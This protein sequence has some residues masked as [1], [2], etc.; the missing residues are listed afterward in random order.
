MYFAIGCRRGAH[1]HE[2]CRLM[3]GEHGG[4]L[5]DRKSGHVHRRHGVFACRHFPCGRVRMAGGNGA[6]GSARSI[7]SVLAV[8]TSHPRYTAHC[9]R[10]SLCVPLHAEELINVFLSFSPGQRNAEAYFPSTRTRHRH[11]FFPSRVRAGD[12]DVR[13][14][15]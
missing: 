12:D 8:N 15:N 9:G 6:M 14:H 5:S 13:H 4:D 2:I 11:G 10:L 3:T 1:N 7:S